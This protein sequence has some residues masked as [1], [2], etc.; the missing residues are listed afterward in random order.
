MKVRID[1]GLC[2]SCGLC[3]QICPD[4]FAPREDDG[5][6]VIIANEREL[7]MLPCVEE[8]AESCPTEAIII[9]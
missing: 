1:E 4:A 3:S 7:D 9:E 2:I 8:A 6:A 5:I